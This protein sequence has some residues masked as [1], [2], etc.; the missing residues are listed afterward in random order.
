MNTQQKILLVVLLGIHKRLI[1]QKKVKVF[2][3]GQQQ[4]SD[5]MEKA[6]NHESS[7]HS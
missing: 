5:P 1:L 3:W 7:K 4:L 2:R 6:N